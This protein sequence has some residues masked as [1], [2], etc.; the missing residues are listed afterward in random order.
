MSTE[1][2]LSL[3]AATISLIVDRPW[4]LLPVAVVVLV[5]SVLDSPAGGACPSRDSRR[6][7]TAAERREAFERA[8]LQCEHKSILW[9]RCTNTPTQGDH[10]YPWSKGG[11]TAMSNQQTLC[12]FHNSRKSGSVP[13]RMYI[14]RLQ[15]RRRRYFPDDTSPLVEWRPGAAP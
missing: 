14:L 15:Q 8:G 2:A 12:P 10:I 7:F 11:R 9:R 13:T 3:L 4:I 5:C 1:H 6:A